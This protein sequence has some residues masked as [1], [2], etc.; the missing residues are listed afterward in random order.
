MLNKKIQSEINEPSS[1]AHIH[2]TD[3]HISVM[4]LGGLEQI[5]ANCTLI[6]YKDSWIMVD[7]GI[8]F[9]DKL[10]IDVITP[11]ISFPLSLKNKLKGIFITHAH[12]DHIGAVHYFWSRFNCPVYLTEFSAEVLKQ[13]LKSRT[14]DP[15][16]SRIISVFP[17]SPILVDEFKVEFISV[18]HSIL[19]ACGLYIQTLGG[20]LFHTGD[21]KVDDNPLLG[22]KTDFERLSE[23]GNNGGV[24]CLLCDST[25]VLVL[26]DAGSESDVKNSLDKLITKY[27]NKRITITC[28]ASNVARIEAICELAQKH[29]RK[30]VIIGR[31]IYRMIDAVTETNYYTKNFKRYIDNIVPD[32]QGA[33]MSPEQVLMICTGSQGEAKSAMYRLAR[34]ENRFIKLGKQDV[35]LFSSKVIPGNEL[36]IREMQNSLI[37]MGV[38]FVTSDFEPDIHVSGHPNKNALRKMYDSLKP[39]ALIPLHGDP[40]MLHAHKDF[41]EE[42]GIKNTV[43]AVSGDIITVH[44]GDGVLKKLHHRNVVYNALDGKYI[45]PIN[46]NCLMERTF[47]STQGHIS[48]SFV[49]DQYNKLISNTDILIRGVFLT[50]NLLST[51]RKN[52]LSI[53]TNQLAKAEMGE[54]VINGNLR[55]DLQNDVKQLFSKLC[56]KKPVINIHVHQIGKTFKNKFSNEEVL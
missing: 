49:I 32:E 31:S 14:F 40:V 37:Q 27:K 17:R 4:P 13:K 30:V 54:S 18:A 12:E 35:V 38:N 43:F 6:G 26:E 48:I 45:I 44:K 3:D 50:P 47:M 23:I 24:D 39:K 1:N 22:D 53:I 7:L 21:W 5:G 41:A 56:D 46:S 19:G 25:N 8:A 9:H 16:T 28:F 15:E 20:S 34:G 42:C 11:D 29:N 2:R 10:G 55:R 52:I 36:S 51:V 33:S